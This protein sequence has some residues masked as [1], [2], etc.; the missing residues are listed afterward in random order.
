[1][2][3]A[4]AEQRDSCLLLFKFWLRSE[5]FSIVSFAIEAL[6]SRLVSANSTK[7]VM[8]YVVHFAHFRLQIA[9][10]FSRMKEKSLSYHT[11]FCLPFETARFLWL[12]WNLNHFW[13]FEPTFQSYRSYFPHVSPRITWFC[14]H[15]SK[16]FC[17]ITLLFVCG[18]IIFQKLCS[19]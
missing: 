17:F 3:V 16:R 5:L 12:T 13:P 1:M 7:V 4:H 15:L 9:W 19:R 6:K 11:F 18:M 10:I 14:T 8:F 2:D